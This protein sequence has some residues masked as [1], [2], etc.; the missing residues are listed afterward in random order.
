MEVAKIITDTLRATDAAAILRITLEKD[1][2]PVATTLF[3][4]K[5]GKFIAQN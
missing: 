3:A 5:K 1:F 2:W 4:K